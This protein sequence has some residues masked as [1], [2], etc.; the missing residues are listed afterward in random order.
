MSD[1]NWEAVLAVLALAAFVGLIAHKVRQEQ[2]RQY[3]R[4]LPPKHDGPEPTKPGH[5]DE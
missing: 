1:F 2:A 5:N 4:P 3:K